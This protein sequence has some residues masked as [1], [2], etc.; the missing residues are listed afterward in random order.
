MRSFG[1]V[2]TGSDLQPHHSAYGRKSWREATT[3]VRG[4]S[5]QTV[6]GIQMTW[7]Q[8][9]GRRAVGMWGWGKARWRVTEDGVERALGL[10]R[11]GVTRGFRHASTQ[12]SGLGRQET[13]TELE[14][15]RSELGAQNITMVWPRGVWD[16]QMSKQ[17]TKYTSLKLKKELWVG[18]A[19]LEL[20]VCKW[21][22]SHKLV[23]FLED[24]K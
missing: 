19:G 7:W 22:W 1:R 2:F 6:S 3:W 8:A 16:I 14:P 15:K 13:F 24:I 20:S 11:W 21:S 17:N 23:I 5:W 9:A 18:E 10:L 4:M 12:D